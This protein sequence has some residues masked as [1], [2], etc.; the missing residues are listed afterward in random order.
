MLYTQ[1]RAFTVHLHIISLV[2]NSNTYNVSLTKTQFLAHIQKSVTLMRTYHS[3][4][5]IQVKSKI[6]KLSI[7][8]YF[9]AFVSSNSIIV[10]VFSYNENQFLHTNG[11]DCLENKQNLI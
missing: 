4:C 6:Y 3:K 11:I 5:W 7:I 10:M 1:Q 8:L 2:N 9:K